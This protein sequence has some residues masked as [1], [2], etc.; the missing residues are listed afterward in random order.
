MDRTKVSFAE[1]E[2]KAKFPAVL[3]WGEIDQRLRSSLW[4]PIFIFLEDH[5][6]ESNYRSPGHHLDDNVSGLMTREFVHRRHLFISDYPYYF[7]KNEYLKNWSDFFKTANYVDL[8]DFLTFVVRDSDCPDDL[9]D[10]I[11][12]ALDQPFSPLS[13]LQGSQDD[14][15]CCRRGRNTV[16]SEGF[17]NC[18]FFAFSWKQNAFASGSS[19][20]G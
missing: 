5:I 1:A 15:P 11:V 8:F 18:L 14:F 2:G 9:M 13:A 16:S 4:T 10:R 17:A 20:V 12:D 6:L 19:G 3:K 7:Y